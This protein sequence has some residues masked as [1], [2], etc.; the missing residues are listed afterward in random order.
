MSFVSMG[1]LGV[2]P[3]QFNKNTVNTLCIT[4]Q[5]NVNSVKIVKL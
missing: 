4:V 3:I 2:A 1:V 5:G